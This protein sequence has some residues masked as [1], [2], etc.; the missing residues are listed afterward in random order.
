MSFTQ[1]L[2]GS[3]VLLVNTTRSDSSKIN[4][5]KEQLMQKVTENGLVVDETL[6]RVVHGLFQSS[7]LS[8]FV[9]NFNSLNFYYFF[10]LFQAISQILHTI[11]FLLIIMVP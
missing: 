2:P 1:V 9:F 11:I 4:E 7:A 6:D 5:T 10:L 3:K 8:F